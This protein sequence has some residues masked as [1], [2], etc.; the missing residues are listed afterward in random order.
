[1]IK[2]SENLVLDVLKQVLP[3]ITKIRKFFYFLDGIIKNMPV[4]QNKLSSLRFILNGKYLGCSKRSKTI[5]IGYGK[6]PLQS[7]FVEGINTFMS[8]NHRYGLFGLTVYM[9]RTFKNKL[10]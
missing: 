8:Y 1:L 6:I 7:I 5:I 2:N 4:I 9:N 3:K 10:A